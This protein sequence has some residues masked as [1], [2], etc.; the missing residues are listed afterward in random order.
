MR[1]RKSQEVLGEAKNVTIRE[2][3][4]KWFILHIFHGAQNRP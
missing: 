3:C 2:S 1:Y 4:G